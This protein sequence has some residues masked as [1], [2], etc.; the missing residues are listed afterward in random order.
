MAMSKEGVIVEQILNL[1]PPRCKDEE[2]KNDIM[3][4]HM[5]FKLESAKISL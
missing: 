1:K 2:I 4:Q 5:K 3:I